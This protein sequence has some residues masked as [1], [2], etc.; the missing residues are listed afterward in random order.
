MGVILQF[1]FTDQR[2]IIAV[3]LA[4]L[5]LEAFNVLELMCCKNCTWL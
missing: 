2:P 4:I 3:N 1:S 5:F